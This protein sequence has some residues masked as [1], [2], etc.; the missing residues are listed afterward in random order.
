MRLRSRG[1]I[2]AVAVIVLSQLIS[3]SSA[4][5]V[6][7]P[8]VDESRLVPALSPSFVPWTC[9][10][11]QSGPVCTG[12]RHVS[13][14]WAAF[15]FGCGETPLWFSNRSD[16]W[17]TRFYNME[18]LDFYREFRTKDVDYLSTSPTGPATATIRT[19]ARFVEH[20][21]VPGDDGTRTIITSGVLWDIRPSHGP[22][23]WRAVGTLVEPPDAEATFTGRVTTGGRTTHY[24]DTPLHEVLSD[25]T[26]VNAVCAAAS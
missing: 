4:S 26:F 14:D 13:S 19:H 7:R 12:E 24:V 2:A 10:V 15:D 1:G 22:A 16:R 5:S 18:Y 23:Q 25:D 3:P 9:K 21:A 6:G 17:Q 8:P 11:K 20:F